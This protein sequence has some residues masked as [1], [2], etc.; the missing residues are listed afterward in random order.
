MARRFLFCL[1]LGLIAV[2]VPPASAQVAAPPLVE[3]V[4]PALPVSPANANT[5]ASPVAWYKGA[6]YTANVEPSEG[7]ATGTNLRTVVRKGTR[8]KDGAWTWAVHVIEPRTIHDPWHNVPSIAVDRGGF[9]H[10]AYNMHNMP[11]QYAVSE[12]AEDISGFVFR[13]EAVTQ[14]QLDLVKFQNRTPFA[15]PGTGA[16]PGN[17]VTYPAFF[18]DRKGDLYV[19]YR[20]AVR[21]KKTYAARAYAAGIAVYDIARRTWSPIGWPVEIGPDDA[22]LAADLKTATSYPFAM[23]DGWWALLPRLW[24]DRNNGMHVTWVWRKGSAGMDATHPSYAFSPDRGKAFRRSDGSPY[25]APVTPQNADL[26]VRQGDDAKFYALTSLASDP[27]GNMVALVMPEKKAYTLVR[28]DAKTRR[29]SEPVPSPFGASQI[30]IDD[31][32]T[33]WAFASGPRILTRAADAAPDAPWATVYQETG[34]CYPKIARAD[35]ERAFIIHAQA[36]DSTK[37]RILM[38]R[39]R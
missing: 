24:F 13:G 3:E 35:D 39:K 15:S 5:H 22:D 26:L 36:C 21:P 9:V 37:V 14:E 10:V 11:W 28:W 17:G 2:A 20:Y 18:T 33:Q 34:F 4:L 31:D 6:V 7:P 25:S 30:L 19:T 12:R 29:W 1:A 23:Q 38:F 8:G 27:A 32:G 16:I